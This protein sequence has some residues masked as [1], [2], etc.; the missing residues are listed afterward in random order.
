MNRSPLILSTAALLA[1]ALLLCG[2]LIRD[3]LMAVAAEVRDKQVPA[4]PPEVRLTL[5]NPEAAVTLGKARLDGAPGK[6]GTLYLDDIR[7]DLPAT[8]PAK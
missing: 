1:I 6:G 4:F 3:G 8:Q 7:I 2:W 5:G